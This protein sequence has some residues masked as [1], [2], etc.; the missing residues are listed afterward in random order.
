MPLDFFLPCKFFKYIFGFRRDYLN[1]ET[2]IVTAVVTDTDIG[3]R[4]RTWTP[5]M[6]MD[7]GQGHES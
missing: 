6:D 1:H 7:I 2:D 5:G 3:Y 4:T